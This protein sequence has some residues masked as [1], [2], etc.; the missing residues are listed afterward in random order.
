[1][2][3]YQLYPD[4]VRE[5]YE[6]HKLPYV[7]DRTVVNV[8]IEFEV[9]DLSQIPIIFPK[10]EVLSIE[11][12]DNAISDLEPLQHCK[13]LKKLTITGN[14]REL[15]NTHLLHKKLSILFG[16][17]HH[18]SEYPRTRIYE[19]IK[20]ITIYDDVIM[21]HMDIDAAM[22]WTNVDDD[23]II[24][25]CKNT[26]IMIYIKSGSLQT[27]KLS[28]EFAKRIIRLNTLPTSI[29]DLYQDMSPKID[30]HVLL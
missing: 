15:I 8:E 26:Y 24:Q 20:N 7:S 10:V 11:L 23:F 16:V 17:V 21:Y 2:T 3:N 13:N 27:A 28:E 14:E 12:P 18:P 9:K 25:K 30:T 22:S 29:N 6:T 5:G 1:M 19:H 4:S